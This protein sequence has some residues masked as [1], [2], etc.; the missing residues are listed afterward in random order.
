MRLSILLTSALVLTIGAAH[1]ADLAAG[2]KVFNKCRACHAIGEGAKNKV[3]P[4]LNGV[5]GRPWGAIEGFKYSAGKEGTLMAIAESGPHVWD[6][7]TLRA[8]LRKPKDVVPR[9]K[10][11]FPGLKSD[12][13]IENVIHYLAQFDPSGAKVDPDAVLAKFPAE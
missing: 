6:P 13:D 9:S 3:G 2:E 12:E 5:V 7:A 1:A 11:A 4:E 8:Y 10:M